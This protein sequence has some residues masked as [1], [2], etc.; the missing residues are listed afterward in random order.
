MRA[1][2]ISRRAVR[3]SRLVVT[4]VAALLAT[5]VLGAASAGADA[6]TR[7][8]PGFAD[9]NGLACTS[10]TTCTGV[11]GANTGT[12]GGEIVSVTDGVPGTPVSVPGV[13]V[14]LG[15]ACP[16][17][18][19]CVA[20]GIATDGTL[21]LDGLVQGGVQQVLPLNV[22]LHDAATLACP[23]STTCLIFTDPNV[24]VVHIASDGTLSATPGAPIP[25]GASILAASCYS[26]TACVAVGSV[27]NGG[28]FEGFTLPVTN[29]VPGTP[30][31]VNGTFQLDAISCRSTGTCL[32]GGR[33]PDVT[34]GVLVPVTLGGVG[35]VQST[36]TFIAFGI[37]CPINSECIESGTDLA[38]QSNANGVV[39]SATPLTFEGDRVTCPATTACLVVGQDT[40]FTAQVL[41]LSAGFS[42]NP[43]SVAFAQRRYNTTSTAS[44]VTVTNTGNAALVI[45]SATI[46]GAGVAAFHI[47]SNSCLGALA[48]GA[49]CAT[50]VTFRPTSDKTFTGALS[51]TDNAPGS[52]HTVTLSGRGCAVLSGPVC[53]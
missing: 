48:P 29:G 30:V 33:G 31:L 9:F 7:P 52:P 38:L 51:Y 28:D 19:L 47:T 22:T 40:T 11:G 13:S 10:A 16:T 12:G 8:V 34:H 20:D 21:V 26:A 23:T 44:T 17:A 41:T 35:A 14:F 4:A 24:I 37:G 2:G 15:V 45:S 50:T 5:S 18:S 36:G 32:T 1:V 6:V 25:A 27:V 53:I 43:T 46:T 42:A 39:A 49:H 3:S